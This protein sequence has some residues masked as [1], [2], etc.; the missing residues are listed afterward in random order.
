M[1][2]AW[3]LAA[4]APV[5][6]L[7]AALVGGDEAPYVYGT[8]PELR[9][10]SSWRA[11]PTERT[12]VEVDADGFTATASP[13]N[14]IP[15]YLVNDRFHGRVLVCSDVFVAG[16]AAAAW[17]LPQATG[18]RAAIHREG[19]TALHG[20]RRLAPGSV[21][22][23][24]RLGSGWAVDSSDQADPLDAA[25]AP[26][27]TDP[28]AAGDAFVSAL[29]D[30]VRVYTDPG[31]PVATMLSEGIDSG[32]VTTLA[33]RAGLRVTAYSAGTPWGDEYAGAA[34]LAGHL[35]IAHRRIDLTAAELIGAVPE[36]I[37]VL[38]HAHPEKVDI[39]V[40]AVALLRRGAVV[41]PQVLTGYGSDLLNLG[42]PVST[43]DPA[44]LI[45]IIREGID[46]TRYSGELT[47]VFATARGK[48]LLH[49][50]WHPDVVATALAVHP[51]CKVDG[52]REKA[53]F[54]AAMAR[55]LP[56]P[57]AWRRKVAV[58]HGGGLQR[59]LNAC[60]GGAQA[61]A[62]AYLDCFDTV[63]ARV[64]IDPLGA[65]HSDAVARLLARAPGMPRS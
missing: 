10:G 49:P 12:G 53:Y 5:P 29:A 63:A 9:D 58:H 64:R 20:V 35:G 18:D 52:G 45:G 32:A 23:V 1:T 8:R 14:E 17:G 4:T 21:T 38:G 31:A 55:Q 56:E 11:G 6:P 43:R 3:F 33:H 27:L 16:S 30:A 36:V 46:D 34:E 24:R 50:Y 57:I 37:R 48:R 2:H 7:A 44:E 42:L 15:L 41:E 51:H 60:F 13:L 22:R 28:V 40:T 19:S 25:L 47:T 26:T 59:G 54:R 39:A 65:D 62:E 61:K